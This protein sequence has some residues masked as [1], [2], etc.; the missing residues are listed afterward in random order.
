MRCHVAIL[1][2]P[3]VELVLA[4]RKTVESRLTQTKHPPFGMIK[5]GDMIYFKVS[6]GPFA[7]I[8]VAGPVEQY[9]S[10]SKT[11]MRELYQRL[12]PLVCAGREYWRERNA[13]SYATFIHLQR[14]TPLTIGPDYAKSAWRAWHVIDPAPPLVYDSQLTRGGIRNRYV[15]TR[16]CG[17]M[18]SE[19]TFTLQLPDGKMVDTKR[20]LLQR[21]RWRGWEPYFE[22]AGVGVGD[23]VRFV[24]EGTGRY[25]VLFIKE[26]Q[27]NAQ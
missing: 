11:V 4:G 5:T 8:A 16:Q 17:K 6:G 1:K 20:Y 22:Q 21:I 23:W 7:A 3:Y 24:R 10:P 9:Q 25:R 15:L 12:E 18:F 14:V 27:S 19:K 26:N 13:Y 2:K